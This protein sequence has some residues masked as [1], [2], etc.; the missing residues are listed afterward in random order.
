MAFAKEYAATLT[1]NKDQVSKI[2]IAQRHIYDAGIVNPNSNRLASLLSSVAS[3]LGLAFV[4]S[5]PV[6]LATGVT[7]LVA[8][9]L[10]N[11]KGILESMVKEG[12][13]QLGYVED[14]FRASNDYDLIQVQMPFIEYET[15]KVRF[16]TGKCVIKKI[17]KKN[18][19]WLE[20]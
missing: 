14:F 10:P 20:Y 8:G 5:T 9:M 17:H 18:G 3:V 2:A 7:A 16:V 4:A 12:Y 1:L 19:P 15:A 6:G 13:W 11:E